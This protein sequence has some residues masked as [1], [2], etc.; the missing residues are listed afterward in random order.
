[1]EHEC[2][3]A[4]MGHPWSLSNIHGLHIHVVT[5]L[6]NSVSYRCAYSAK[7]P[8]LGPMVWKYGCNSLRRWR[9]RS[10]LEPHSQVGSCVERFGMYMKTLLGRWY[11]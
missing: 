9:V 6:D 1:M 10:W 2:W 11:I 7:T 3:M 8:R 5:G 4:W